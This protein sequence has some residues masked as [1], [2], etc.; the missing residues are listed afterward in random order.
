[1]QVYM[2]S[3][4]MLKKGISKEEEFEPTMTKVLEEAWSNR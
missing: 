1:M 2:K 4:S 3:D